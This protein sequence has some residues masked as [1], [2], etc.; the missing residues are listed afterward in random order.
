MK[1]HL[2]FKPVILGAVLLT[3]EENGSW[4]VLQQKYVH[5]SFPMVGTGPYYRHRKKIHS[6][7][8]TGT[9]RRVS[10]RTTMMEPTL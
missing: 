10:S 9:Q 8:W 2:L 6:F 7:T 4:F 3:Q 1:Q 5:A